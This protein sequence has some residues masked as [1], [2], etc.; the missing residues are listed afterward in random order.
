[1]KT[2]FIK[3]NI[4]PI[5]F[6]SLVLLTCILGSKLYEDHQKQKIERLEEI[7]HLKTEVQEKEEVIE[8]LKVPSEIETMEEVVNGTFN[9]RNEVREEKI[10]KEVEMQEI[11]KAYE[12]LDILDRELTLKSRCQLEQAMRKIQEKEYSLE[13]CESPENL[14]KFSDG[15]KEEKTVENLSVYRHEW[16]D[17]RN[18]WLDYLYVN[19]G[20]DRDMILTFLSEN[21]NMGIDR[22]SNFKGNDGNYAYGICQ[23]YYTYHKD[24]INSPGFQD[25][26]VQMDYCIGVWNDAEKRG[27]LGDTFH[28]YSF[29]YNAAPKVVFNK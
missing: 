8:E 6:I 24:F 4:K 5:I 20:Y 29:R 25:P 7:V 18:E 26:Y 17:H 3:R 16:N 19:S 11:E 28:A 10:I 27:I 23:L 2:A 22:P 1:M 14:E 13:Y 15:Y 21:D 9:R 12:W